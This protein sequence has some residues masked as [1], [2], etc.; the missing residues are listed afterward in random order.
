MTNPHLEHLLLEGY[1]LSI[2][3]ISRPYH[4]PL[5][6]SCRSSGNES[7]N[8][9]S[10]YA[11]RNEAT[12]DDSICVAAGLK[13]KALVGKNGAIALAY[14]DVN[15]KI[16]IAVG[17]EGESIEAGKMYAVNEIGEFIVVEDK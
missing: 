15:G 11:S 16:R 14:K 12:G 9:S 1:H 2:P 3:T 7:R 6:S 8:A 5:Y 10:G 17:Y 4:A 13:S